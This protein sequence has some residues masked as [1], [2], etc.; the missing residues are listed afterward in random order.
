[1]GV[2]ETEE[3][4]PLRVKVIYSLSSLP[5]QVLSQAFALWIIF[6]YAPPSDED[7]GAFLPALGLPA[8]DLGFFSLPDELSP[9]V[10]LGLA[11]TLMRILDSIDDPVIGY[12][13][14]RTSSR[15]GRRIPYIVLASPWWALLFVALFLPPFAGESAGNIL[16]LIVVVEGYWLASNFSGAPL[17][18]LLPHIARSHQ[19]RVTVGALQLIFGVAGAFIGLT[20]SSLLVDS[21]GFPMMAAVMATV[22]LVGRYLALAGCW[23]Q[24]RTDD[25]PATGGLIRSVR[26]TFSNPNFLAFLPSSVLFRLGQ[27]MLTAWLPFYVATVLRDVT[28]LGRS[29]AA[30]SGLFTSALTVLVI[31]GILCGIAVFTPL[32]RR[33]GKASAFRISMLSGSVMLFA[34]FFSGFVPGIPTVAQTIVSVFGAALPLA[35]VF[36]LPGILIADIVDHDARRTGTRREGM[37][38]GTQNLV[39]KSASA[40]APL[41]FSLV[42]LAGDSAEHPLGIRLVGPVAGAL[43]LLGWISFRRYRLREQLSPRSGEEAERAGR[44][45]PGRQAP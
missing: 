41:L 22:A 40:S 42:L 17:E 6:F 20:I 32:A 5:S 16:W 13:T 36:M 14:D 33:L 15:W 43:L 27:L 30:D 8:L 23:Q 26:E 24:A 10:L 2:V 4:R 1:M 19:D 11:L 18:A 35:G 45:A 3:S 25:R 7:R 37:F 29:G 12:L 34:L 9:R 44:L 28:V 38:Y 21:L 31:A 39:E